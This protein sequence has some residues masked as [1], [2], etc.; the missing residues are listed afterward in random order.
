MSHSERCDTRRVSRGRRG[1]T[2][3]LNQSSL[4][5]EDLPTIGFTPPERKP[6][7]Q[8][9][10]LVK[11]VSQRVSVLSKLATESLAHDPVFVARNLP[12]SHQSLDAGSRPYT[13]PEAPTSQKS[14]AVCAM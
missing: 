5:V 7:R 9:S 11:P 1:P 12:P 8:P 6:A 10:R 4:V 2:V 3:V 14:S 13:C